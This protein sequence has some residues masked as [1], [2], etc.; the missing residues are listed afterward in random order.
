M[1]WTF[2]C[3]SCDHSQEQHT[4]VY[5]SHRCEQCGVAK[6]CCMGCRHYDVYSPRQCR[7]PQV[8]PVHDKEKANFCGH[9]QPGTG[10]SD[11]V[12]QQAEARAKL[13]ALFKK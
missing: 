3:W 2:T 7:E 11:E 4:S 6:H 1:T 10:K 9:F 12:D 8:E 13:D 5:R